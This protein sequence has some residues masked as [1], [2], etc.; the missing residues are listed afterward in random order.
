MVKG[1]G[2]ASQNSTVGPGRGLLRCIPPKDKNSVTAKLLLEKIQSRKVERKPSV[3]EEGV[4]ATPNK[5]KSQAQ[6]PP[7]GYFGPKLPLQQ[8]ACPSS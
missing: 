8:Q 6:G 3:S 4:L 5:A 2:P 1:I 7:Q